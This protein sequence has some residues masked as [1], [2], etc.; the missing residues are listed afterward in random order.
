MSALRATATGAA[1]LTLLA[2]LATAAACAKAVTETPDV[3][4]ASPVPEADAAAP[5]AAFADA[6][7][8]RLPDNVE[9]AEETTQVFVVAADRGLY[10]FNPEKLEIVRVGTLDCPTAA[11]TFSMAIDRRGTAYVE[12]QDGR[13]F[14]VDTRDA[15]CQPTAFQPNQAGFQT[16]GMGYARDDDDAGETLYASGAGLAALDT[17]TF[18]L[19]FKGSLALGRTELTG[20]DRELYA[21]SVGSGVVGRL[22]KNTGAVDQT[23][24]TT[25]IDESAAFAFAHWGGDFWIFTGNATSK[26]TKYSPTTDTSTDVLSNTG[27]LIV[28]AGSSTCA[29]TA[30]PR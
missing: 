9:C 15:T 27:I 22:N 10:R 30:P 13:L 3:L 17:K 21:F 16:F 4:P 25:A 7:R 8:P 28:G 26:V 2:L 12:F 6:G 29:P 20:K 19:K 14:A 1:L 23:Y 11:G 5:T 24:R 18:Q